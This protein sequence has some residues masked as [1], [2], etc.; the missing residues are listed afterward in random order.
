MA[1]G[2]EGIGGLVQLGDLIV[3]EG[4]GPAL[5]V[6]LVVLGLPHSRPYDFLGEILVRMEKII[7]GRVLARGLDPIGEDVGVDR[8]RIG[9]GGVQVRGLRGRFCDGTRSHC[10]G[11]GGVQL[12]GK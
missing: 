1:S 7:E 4:M 2:K 12:K 5:W 11:V 3:T 8:G 6:V 9:L 10:S